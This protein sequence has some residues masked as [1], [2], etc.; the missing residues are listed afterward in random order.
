M[1]PMRV[2][3]AG[4]SSCNPERAPQ[5]LVISLTTLCAPSRTERIRP[6]LLSPPNPCSLL[7]P[8]EREH[9]P[10]VRWLA[11]PRKL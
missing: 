3:P 9:E 4:R 6:D 11:R 2:P 1:A 10:H 8:I 7:Q 5:D